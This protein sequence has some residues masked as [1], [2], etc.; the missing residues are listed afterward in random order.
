MIRRDHILRMVAEMA[1]VLARVISLK[2]RQE[3]EQALKEIHAA[4]CELRGDSAEPSLADWIALCRKHEQSAAGLMVAVA[5]LLK[6]QGD[7]QA[8]QG[9][10]DDGTR[11]RSMALGLFLEALLNGETFVTAEMLA[12]TEEL[13]AQVRGPLSDAGVWRR[14]VSYFEA[15]GRFARAE[16]ALFAWQAT[17]DPT[18][19][20]EG[21]AFYQRIGTQDDD[22]LVRGDLPR[23]ELEQGRREFT[24]AGQRCD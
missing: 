13:F 3:Y 21:L 6:E 20:T 18:V 1:Q 24:A 16:D 19:T 2:S 7:V 5:N 22:A 8:A 17:G 9:K 23:A 15:R 12:K 14:L 10:P 4:L 11:S